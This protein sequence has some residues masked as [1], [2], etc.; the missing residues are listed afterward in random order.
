MQKAEIAGLQVGSVLIFERAGA[1]AMTEGMALF[2][3]HELPQ[4]ALYSR[5]TGWKLVRTKYETYEWN[6]EKEI[7][8]GNF[9]EHFNGN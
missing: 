9:N 4:I 2:L 1:Y 6:M 7:N 3:S 5:E 8:D